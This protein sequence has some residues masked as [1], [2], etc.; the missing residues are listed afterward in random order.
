MKLFIWIFS[1]LFSL[2]LTA[3]AQN[4]L[5]GVIINADS[6]EHNT[7]SKTVH[8]RGNVQ[9]VFKGNHLRADEATLYLKTKTVKA[10]GRVVM[11]NQKIHMEGSRLEMDY[12]TVKGKLYDGFVQSGKVVFQGEVVEKTGPDDFIATNAHY[13]S[14]VDCPPDWSFSGTKIKATIGGYADI[15]YP[16]FKVRGVPIFIFPWLPVPLKSSRQS[17]F[18]VPSLGFSGTGGFAPE[19]PYFWAISRSQDATITA[20]S[21]SLRGYKGLVEYRYVM[22]PE[23]SGTLRTAYMHDRR[24]KV[25]GLGAPIE[26]DR[27]FIDYRHHY[28]LPNQYVHRLKITTASDL[29]YQKDFPLELRGNGDPAF[30]NRMSLT[31]NSENTHLSGETAYYINLLKANPQANNTD[32]VHR[33]PEI[34]YNVAKERLG[35]SP[36]IF[37]FDADYTNFFRSSS[38]FDSMTCPGGKCTVNEANFSQKFSSTFNSSTDFIRSGQRL[39]LAPKITAPFRLLQVLDFLPAAT[40]H[41]TDYTFDVPAGQGVST[42]ASRRYVQMD[43]GMRTRFTSVYKG[44]EDGYKHIIEPSINYSI[45][46]WIHQPNH[47]FFGDTNQPYARTVEPIGNSDV[48]NV[49]GTTKVQFDYFDRVYNRRIFNLGITNYLNRRRVYGAQNNYKNIVTWTLGQSYDLNEVK[50]GNRQP[51]SAVNSVLDVRL[52]RFE[53]YLLNV[54]YPYVDVINTSARVRVLDDRGDFLE[55]NYMKKSLI[56]WDNLVDPNS[57]TETAGISLGIVSRF[58]TFAGGVNYSLP[59]HKLQSWQYRAILK[60][61]SCW[62]VQIGHSQIL[63]GDVQL[64]FNFSFDFGGQ[65][66]LN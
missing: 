61:R 66:K 15:S 22:T 25:A 41:E 16:I 48:S 35:N 38:G 58:F 44:R 36:F 63:G 17:G 18:L 42:T 57:R 23:S 20:K 54:F 19:L 50:G 8:L 11:E 43:L 59:D 37:E 55:A 39:D 56:S 64:S 34:R 24:F 13:T 65:Q 33:L 30:E 52:D 45:I 14:C 21:Y 2:P 7:A 31:K 12:D 6:S 4:S 32:A 26:I 29:T 62:A 10:S 5:G 27:W 1:L 3:L 51:W 40:F 9:V 49:Q 28:V 47:P 46:P 53:T 60:P